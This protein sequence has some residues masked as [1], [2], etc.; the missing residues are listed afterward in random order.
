MSENDKHKRAFDAGNGPTPPDQ[1]SENSGFQVDPNQPVNA[2]LLSAY[3]D[4][5]DELEPETRRRIEQELAANAEARRTLHELEA[6]V[7]GLQA[8]PDI[9]APRSYHLTPEMVGAPEPVKLQETKAW[10]VRHSESVRWAT[11][12]AA[13]LFIFVFT[14]DLVTN[15]IGPGDSSDGANV[16]SQSGDT[17]DEPAGVRS[18]DEGASGGDDA[19][20]E[21]EAEM[22]PVPEDGAASDSG[23]AAATATPAPVEAEEESAEDAGG[24]ADAQESAPQDDAAVTSAEAG[25]EVAESE[26]ETPV[27]LEAPE[28]AATE[29]QGEAVP[30]R[31]EADTVSDDDAAS[32]T[33][34]TEAQ[35]DMFTVAA[36]DADEG[37]SDSRTVWRAAEFSLIIVLALLLTIMIILPRLDRMPPESRGR[38]R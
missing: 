8:L 13:I 23:D 9:A 16:T 17:A 19:D 21:A 36:E 29:A 12:A 25:G 22:Q 37:G 27:T 1:A 34:A 5:P 26:E 32:D 28:E 33:G 14:A 7:N 18:A 24:G 20:D 15:G 31:D 6:I 38:R 4:I 10:Y 2:E 30:D 11:A 35:E 3:L